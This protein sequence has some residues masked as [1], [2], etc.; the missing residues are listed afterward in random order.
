MRTKILLFILSFIG[1]MVSG[2]AVLLIAIFVFGVNANAIAVTHPTATSLVIAVYGALAVYLFFKLQD[3][4]IVFRPAKEINPLPKS[5]VLEKLERAFCSSGGKKLFDFVHEGDRA[6]VTWASS[7]NYVQLSSTGGIGKKRVVALRLD[8]SKHTAFFVM[9]NKD[10]DWDL[11]ANAA[12]A[13]LYYAVGI[14]TEFT[15]DW[16][17]SIAIGDDGSIKVDIK[18][19]TYNSND[20]WLPIQSCFLSSGWTLQ[21]DMALKPWQRF[22]SALSMAALLYFSVRFILTGGK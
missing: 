3:V 7:I 1:V 5:G 15:A 12:S 4:F 18:K 19:L 9:K 21:S 10:W 8:A 22:V 14:S 2:P 6:A 20:L 11:S 16:V 13:S 17:P